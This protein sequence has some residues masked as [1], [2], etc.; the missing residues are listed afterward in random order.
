MYIIDIKDCHQQYFKQKD[1]N[2]NGYCG[3]PSVSTRGVELVLNVG[4]ERIWF[5]EVGVEF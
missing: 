2:P 5:S 3:L 4:Y 1:K